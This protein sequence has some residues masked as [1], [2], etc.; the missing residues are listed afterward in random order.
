M[1]GG[2]IAISSADVTIVAS[3]VLGRSAISDKILVPGRCLV[4]HP[5]R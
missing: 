3:L 2:N 1:C 4:V 5:N